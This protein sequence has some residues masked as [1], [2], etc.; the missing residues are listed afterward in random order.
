VR[1]RVLCNPWPPNEGRC[2]SKVRRTI[3]DGAQEL[4]EIQGPGDAV[5]ALENDAPSDTTASRLWGRVLYVHGQGID[6]PLGVIRFDYSD[7]NSTLEP[8]YEPG[9]FLTALHYT[10]RGALLFPT[11]SDGSGRMCATGS[12]LN[13]VQ[14]GWAPMD[15]YQGRRFATA[16]PE[17]SWL[18]TL[19]EG[20][21]ESTGL[22]YRRNRYYDPTTGRFTQ[23][24]PIG[25]AGGLNAYGFA[26]GDP[27]NFSDPFGLC[28]RFPA[29]A[30]AM[31][32]AY[33]DVGE[34]IGLAIG[35]AIEPGGGTAVGAET[36]ATIGEVL[37]FVVAAASD[38][39]RSA[40]GMQK[41][42]EKGRAPRTVDRV[43]PGNKSDPG[44][45]DPQIHFKDGSALTRE[46]RWKHG[47]RTL[48]NTEKKWIL[49][50]KW[51]LPSSEGG[52]SKW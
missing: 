13:C 47:T 46:G 1:G 49:K 45:K 40:G 36:G 25:L 19:L 16:W 9:P 17:W 48:T 18:G 43:D 2:R 6:S 42:V 39:P 5:G 10:W 15:T 50:N 37:G 28:P 51:T 32:A 7:K 11:Y 52:G 24:D 8:R 38:N 35:T 14:S 22:Q 30:F 41:D 44:D 26:N 20:K 3:W 23:E 33:G 27:V 12:I 31:A 34:T 4:W 21:T 29:C